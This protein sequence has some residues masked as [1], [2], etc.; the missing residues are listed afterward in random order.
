M[1]GR[2]FAG[3]REP[4]P[5][6]SPASKALA[7]AAPI[8]RDLD[9][10][11][12]LKLGLVELERGNPVAAAEWI[13]GAIAG[14]PHIAEYHS[15]LGNIRELLRQLDDATIAYRRA[16]DLEP[17]SAQCHF[18]L[19]AVLE[20]LEVFD[21]AGISFE[22][23][24]RL[25]P[26]HALAHYHLGRCLLALGDA[27]NAIVKF[28]R[29]V[30]FDPGLALAHRDLGRAF[31]RIGAG[32]TAITC[33]KRAVELAPQLPEVHFALGRLYAGQGRWPDA[34]DALRVALALDPRHPENWKELGNALGE[35]DESG[36]S[37]EICHRLGRDPSG[38]ARVSAAVFRGLLNLKR[39]GDPAS[40]IRAIR[41]LLVQ[42]WIQRC[43]AEI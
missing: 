42:A 7:S 41:E 2:V 8:P 15:R 11:A 22:N 27:N 18:D 20:K 23:A 37:M 36:E 16:V 32:K 5:T 33:F 39:T 24:L 26:N 38:I 10:E 21:V 28:E 17:R 40:Q 29:A 13:E 30:F 1:M 31:V 3:S 9:P 43:E 19:G 25:D 4:S 14:D 6:A 34:V 35:C 12:K